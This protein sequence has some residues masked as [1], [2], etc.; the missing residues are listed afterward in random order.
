M[1]K[2]SFEVF[3]GELMGAN[4]QLVLKALAIAEEAHE[5][6]LRKDGQTPYIEH[7]T[8]VAAMLYDLGC[9]D[10]VILA[11]AILHDVV[12][13]TGYELHGPGG[14]DVLTGESIIW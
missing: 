12:E 9:R 1:S 2:A 3:R 6:V 13:D 11:A 10:E 4:M 7:P 14:Y 5:G 8:K